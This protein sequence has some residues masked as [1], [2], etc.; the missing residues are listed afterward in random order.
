VVKTGIQYTTSAV[1]P[2]GANYGDKWYDTG[3]DILYEWQTGDG[4]N[5]FWVD[6]GS[7]AI[8][9]N[10]NLS[11]QAFNTVSANNV[12]AAGNISAGNIILGGVGSG[13]VYANNFVFSQNGA[14]I[15][16]SFGVNS[17]G[18]VNVAQ[19]LPKYTGNL[20]AA[21]VYVVGN[22]STSISTGA[23]R[24]VGGVGV[25]GNL[26][27]DG[28][29]DVNGG[30]AVTG[31]RGQISIGNDTR[32]GVARYVLN[33]AVNLYSGMQIKRAG[34]E[35]WFAGANQAEKYVVRYNGA[36]DYVTVDTTGN[37][38]IATTTTSTNT[39]T[40]ALVVKGGAGIAGN[41]T[42]G[43]N[44]SITSNLTVT[45]SGL[46]RGPYNESSTL[47]GVFVGNTGA[48][49]PSPRVGFFNGNTQQNWQIDNF[50]GAFRWFVPGTTKMTLYDSGILNV[51]GG[52]TVG[53]KKAVN[54]PAFR[55]YVSV[56]QTI[57]GAGAQVKVTFGAETFDTDGCFASST[58]TPT[59]EG[60][61]QLNATV[62]IAGT[63]GTGENMLVL[64]KNG[65]EYARG[66]NGS[67]TEIGASFY[68]MQVSDIVYANG[69]TDF[70][71]V[72]IQQGSGSN[73]DTT[74]GTNISYFSGCMI[75]GA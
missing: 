12:V 67:G 50:G 5:G 11:N 55:A 24:V 49:V 59:A 39:T 7:L 4:A 3:T 23:L 42:V 35:L 70:F 18:N 6:I 19:Y 9:A 25:N 56:G 10:A 52:Y 30:I 58:F 74:A 65:G 22:D 63:A 37:L 26:F 13:A 8:Q 61:Y 40:G 69:T 32:D 20:Q 34:T 75:R 57:A 46:F 28:S 72:Y 64:Y 1:A 66:T 48:G 16:D 43:G 54:G 31:S 47:S 44:A 38:V 71:E 2:T 29:G 68:S 14:S 36:V 17:Y 41:I 73:R 15:F 62:R 60:Y 45:H 27:V 51:T 33:T 53:G 21:N